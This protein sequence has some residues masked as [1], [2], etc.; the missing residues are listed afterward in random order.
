MANS[1]FT[2]TP[3]WRRRLA[4][5]RGST[6]EDDLRPYAAPLS[7][8]GRLGRELEPLPDEELQTRSRELAAEAAT[9]TTLDP[10]LPI[11]VGITINDPVLR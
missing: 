7:E 6:I 4:R 10:L 8:I 9:A 11:H 3:S 5:L 2:Q 1:A